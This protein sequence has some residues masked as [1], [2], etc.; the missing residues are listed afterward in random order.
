[1]QE[2]FDLAS[3]AEPHFVQV[4][5]LGWLVPHSHLEDSD[6]HFLRNWY[7]AVSRQWCKRM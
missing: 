5:A 3:D 7:P 2:L 6:S 4:F 1:M